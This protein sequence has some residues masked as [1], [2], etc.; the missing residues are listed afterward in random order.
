VSRALNLGV[1][2][3]W[4]LTIELVKLSDLWFWLPELD[5]NQQ[6]CD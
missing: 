4:I 3:G 6:P 1:L 2:W 5:L